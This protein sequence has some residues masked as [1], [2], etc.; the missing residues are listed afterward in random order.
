[1][2][3]AT[4]GDAD[5]TLQVIEARMC[6]WWVFAVDKIYKD[7]PQGASWQEVVNVG[8]SSE[9]RLT[10]TVGDIPEHIVQGIRVFRAVHP[11]ALSLLFHSDGLTADERLQCL[12]ELCDAVD[13]ADIYGNDQYGLWA[14][15][16]LCRPTQV[17]ASESKYVWA[18]KDA[19]AL[20]KAQTFATEAKDYLNAA[21]ARL[22]AGLEPLKLAKTLVR[23]EY[24]YILADGRTA[25]REFNPSLRARGRVSSPGWNGVSF[26]KASEALHTLPVDGAQ[27]RKLLRTPSEWLWAALAEDEDQLRRFLF[28]FFGLEI[29]INK[30]HRRVEGSVV[31]ALRDGLD[32]LPIEELMW[33]S[34]SDEAQHPSRNLVFRFALVAVALSPATAANDVSIFRRLH[35]ARNNLAHGEAATI[36]DLPV[37]EAIEML[38]QYLVLVGDAIRAAEGA[39]EP[40]LG[41]VD[42]R[43][44]S[45][46]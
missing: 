33:P 15:F 28:S 32:G 13:V 27:L 14:S 7:R 24:A 42:G 18:N 30:T 11:Y 16:E 21:V 25:C 44:F 36:E 39:V 10:V 45:G 17:Q 29:L 5:Q 22:Q 31:G 41:S 8:P 6:V 1:M 46:R 4:N 38:R 40:E 26:E 19:N 37:Q 12:D 43:L 2:A 3:G 34:V 23:T 20:E 9:D 35:R